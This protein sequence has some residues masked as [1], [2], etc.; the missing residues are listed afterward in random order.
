[1]NPLQWVVI[2]NLEK[3]NIVAFG[4]RSTARMTPLAGLF[5][6]VHLEDVEDVGELPRYPQ[7]GPSAHTAILSTNNTTTQ[8]GLA[9]L[10]LNSSSRRLV[11][12]SS[13]SPARGFLID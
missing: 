9:S 5:A 11:F 10:S 7:S 12:L 4:S 6:V 1:M 8:H 13:P 2:N 3:L